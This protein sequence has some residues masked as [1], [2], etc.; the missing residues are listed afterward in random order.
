MSIS[1]SPAQPAVLVLLFLSVSLRPAAHSEGL[2]TASSGGSG[3]RSGRSD[4]LVRVPGRGVR[5]GA[6]GQD[7]RGVRGGDRPD[8]SV[9]PEPK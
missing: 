5:G 2:N 8:S 3:V 9:L 1:V 4:V 7:R 6:C